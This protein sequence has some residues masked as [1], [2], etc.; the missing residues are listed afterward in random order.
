[1]SAAHPDPDFDLLARTL[2]NWG[3][4]VRTEHSDGAGGLVRIKDRHILF[5]P[6]DCPMD[7]KKRY[8]IEAIRKI[9]DPGAHIAPRIRKLLGEEEWDG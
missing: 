5:L 8:C 2:D 3:V 6:I 1:M 4:E 9:M 7:Q